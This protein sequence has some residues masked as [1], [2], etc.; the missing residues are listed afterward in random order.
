MRLNSLFWAR[1]ISFFREPFSLIFIVLTIIVSISS[2]LVFQEKAQS[3]LLVA[4]VSE[5]T[6][7]YSARFLSNL[8]EN[9]SFSMCTLSR[10]DAMQKLYQ[11]KLAAVVVIPDDFSQKI[12]AGI[13]RNTLEL[14][15]S[16]SSEATATIGE[17]LINSV[18]MLWMEEES[19]LLTEEF[20]N[21]QGKTYNETDI[22]KQRNQIL[23][24]WD[25]GSSI[26][27]NQVTMNSDVETSVSLSPFAECSRWY[28]ALC[29]F[30]LM[31][32]ASWIL[33]L[34]KKC[35]RIRLLQTGT[36]RWQVILANSFAPLLICI[37]GYLIAGALCSFLTD[38]NMG[39]I[40]AQALPMLIY[41]CTLLGITLFVASFLKNILS[42]MFIAP[43]LTFLCG[44]LSGLLIVLPE[45]AYMLT[46]ISRILPGRWLNESISVP[47]SGLLWALLC[48]VI[49]IFA[50]IFASA[51][52]SDQRTLSARSA[53]FY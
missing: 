21:E 25:E 13:F 43:I 51:L 19:I 28:A 39:D 45:W 8:S 37:F 35:L 7:E 44:V 26:R 9:E 42:L 36:R 31:I 12:R 15:T 10:E 6:G 30:Y 34:N 40:A 18:M 29:L 5:D 41:L 53:S 3:Q 50:G 23:V 38:S 32:S 16:P 11:D 17:P 1:L 48:C 27:I 33:D 4:I 20:L 52:K 49:W 46:W 47:F 2:A 22:A 14:Y 24:L